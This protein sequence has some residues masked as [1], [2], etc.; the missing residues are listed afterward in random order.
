MSKEKYSEFTQENLKKIGERLRQLRKDRGYSDYNNFAYEHNF[1]RSQYWRYE[2][3]QDLNV[4]TLLRLI[5]VHGMTVPE[6][7]SD[8][9]A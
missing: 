8:G 9:F 7:F 1:G 5:E 4:S 3:G 2:N 6:F